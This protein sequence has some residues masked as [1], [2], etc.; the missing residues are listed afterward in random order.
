[1]IEI[2]NVTKHYGRRAALDGVSLAIV[3]GE[4]TL[5]L[6]RN[7][8]GKSTLL[9]CILGITDFG[10]R[11]DVDGLDPLVNGRD[12]RA[13]I[14]YMPQTGGLHDDLTV[15]ETIAFHSAIRNVSE[16][17]TATLLND[18]G[19][20]AHE[21]AR[22]GEL[23]GGLQQRLAFVIATM[24]DP[25]ILLLDEPS[26]S[27]DDASRRWLAGRLQEFADRGR[28]VVVST[29]TG[30][31]FGGGARRIL[32][33]DGRILT[34]SGSTTASVSNATPEPQAF[35]RT[36]AIRPIVVKELNDAIRTRWLLGYAGLLGVL[37]LVSAGTGMSTTAGLAL[38]VFGRTTATLMS[39][40]LLLAPLVA[41][42]MGAAA[43]AG[44]RDR[45]TLECLL[46][47]PLTRTGLLLGKYAGLLLALAAA[48]LTGFL[49]AGVLV[50]WS[51]G[52]PAL[53]HYL[54]FPG[55]ALAVGAAMLAIGLLVSV[56]SRTAVQA[57]GTA[58]FSWFAFVLLYDL[59]LMGAVA[60]S[61]IGAPA[62][63]A[64][65]VANPID[66][67]RVLSVLALEPDLYLLGP[68]GAYLTSRFSEIGAASLLSA[69][70]VA[71]I[72]VPLAAAALR[73]RLRAG[74]TP[75]SVPRSLLTAA[76]IRRRF[77]RSPEV[78]GS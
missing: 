33:Q 25:S 58:L 55:I 69:G 22:V 11:I 3:P 8:A 63:A 48:T 60:F 13:R 31:D 73:F 40:C 62:L 49:P 71:W 4:V 16:D 23:S 14:G 21:N 32:L 44:E 18:A 17:R 28:T 1:M 64:L 50:A 53:G 19:L 34:D 9:R 54:L 47:Q 27:L 57:Q 59:V 78:S 61:G 24:T 42:A 36:A 5:L 39:L 37:G 52:T 74:R 20:S 7:G 10:G 26:A 43:I 38:Q 2:R 72:A 51:A 29:H 68:A 12:L 46:A 66:S 35:R 67:A 77:L 76:A 56:S 75:V 15:R 30:D 70:L 41:V 65:I 6:G 45:G